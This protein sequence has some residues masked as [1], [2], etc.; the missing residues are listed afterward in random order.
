MDNTPALTGLCPTRKSA[1]LWLT[2]AICELHQ[3]SEAHECGPITLLADIGIQFRL[4]IRCVAMQAFEAFLLLVFVLVLR[5]GTRAVAYV[6]LLTPCVTP[7]H[8]S[9]SSRK[10]CS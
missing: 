8:S 4:E 6:V 7:I 5:L 10:H 1:W 2:D 3:S 9:Q